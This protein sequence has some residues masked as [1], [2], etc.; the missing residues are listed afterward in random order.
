MW[1]DL[2]HEHHES[3]R[4][5]AKGMLRVRTEREGEEAMKEK[6]KLECECCGGP[7]ETPRFYDGFL[8]CAE[9]HGGRKAKLHGMRL[10]EDARLLTGMRRP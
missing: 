9:C 5:A 2:R 3:Q 4:A 8:V 1:T 10:A 7:V 6:L